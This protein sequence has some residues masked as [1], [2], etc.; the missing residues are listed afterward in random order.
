MTFMKPQSKITP[1]AM[2]NSA[3]EKWGRELDSKIEENDG[4]KREQKIS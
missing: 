3:K 4:S 2:R 1:T